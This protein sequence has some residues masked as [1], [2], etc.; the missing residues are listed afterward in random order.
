MWKGSEAGGSGTPLAGGGRR[1]LG[2]S[3]ATLTPG[4]GTGE[5]WK[6]WE[7]SRGTCLGF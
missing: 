1:E 2:A 3:A 4:G 5:N 7:L 6:G